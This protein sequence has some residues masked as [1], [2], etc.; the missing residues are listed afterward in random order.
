MQI[1]NA[2]SEEI[3]SQFVLHSKNL[4]KIEKV[5]KQASKQ[6]TKELDY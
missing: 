4:D 1:E 6:A 3:F 5:S 2:F